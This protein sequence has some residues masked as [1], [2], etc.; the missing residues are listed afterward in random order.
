MTEPSNIQ[1]QPADRTACHLTCNIN[2]RGKTLRLIAGVALI[3]LALLL[4]ALV[5]MSLLTSALGWWLAGV[6]LLSG[7]FLVYE[8]WTG[9]C[10]LR[11]MGISTPI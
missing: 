2:S 9:W 11:A 5:M 3:V 4:G 6:T 10:A 1:N 7:S 8:G